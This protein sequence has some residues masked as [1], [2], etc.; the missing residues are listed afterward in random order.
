M[1]DLTHIS[2]KDLILR[3]SS[4]VDYIKVPHTASQS[5]NT[6]GQKK[7]LKEQTYSLTFNEQSTIHMTRAI[8][9]FTSVGVVVREKVKRNG[10]A[11][12]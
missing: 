1:K 12:K 9:Y 3:N 2:Q 6:R 11:H 8:I 7:T 10:E 5:I 4:D